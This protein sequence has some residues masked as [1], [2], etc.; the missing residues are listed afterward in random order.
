MSHSNK[1]QSVAAF[2]LGTHYGFA[3]RKQDGSIEANG[4]DLSKAGRIA[5]DGFRY[6]QFEKHVRAIFQYAEI[7]VAFFEEVRAHSGVTAAHVWGGF[8][9]T[10]TKVCEDMGVAYCSIPVGTI[11][12]VGTGSGNAG[13]ERMLAAAQ[14]YIPSL[15][16]D[17]NAAD[18]FW[19]LITGLTQELH[20]P[21]L[22]TTHIQKKTS[23][24]PKRSGSAL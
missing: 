20:E 6:L 8:K 10:L 13:K 24:R 4:H 9:A 16:D 1:F 18:A 23:K 3:Y 19:I 17:D 21:N 12:K 11:K 15:P 22:W 2:D 14:H 7:E 5:N